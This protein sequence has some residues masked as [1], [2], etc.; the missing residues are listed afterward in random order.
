MARA[1]QCDICE[2]LYSEYHNFDLGKYQRARLTNRNSMEYDICPD[3]AAAIQE[4]I[5]QRIHIS[6][7]KKKRGD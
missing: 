2:Q 1:F 7:K 6:T 5:D 3:C 4:T